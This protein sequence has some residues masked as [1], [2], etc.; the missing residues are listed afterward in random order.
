MRYKL[1]NKNK[2]LFSRKTY[3]Q[4][5]DKA[6]II[7]DKDGIDSIQLT[8]LKVVRPR[9]THVVPFQRLLNTY[10]AFISPKGK[11]YRLAADDYYF[12]KF[13]FPVFLL[14]FGLILFALGFGMAAAG[15]MLMVGFSP[16]AIRLFL[17]KKNERILDEIAAELKAKKVT[18]TNNA[19]DPYEFETYQKAQNFG[20]H[21]GATVI[22]VLIGFIVQLFAMGIIALLYGQLS[23][24]NTNDNKLLFTVLVSAGSVIITAIP[25]YFFMRFYTGVNF[26]W[27]DDAFKAMPKSHKKTS[28]ELFHRQIIDKR[29]AKNQ[30]LRSSM[31]SVVSILLIFAV[32]FGILF[33]KSDVFDTQDKKVGTISFEPSYASQISIEAKDTAFKFG[34]AV[35][36]K[37][38]MDVAQLLCRENDNVS[39]SSLISNLNAIRFEKN[40]YQNSI[41]QYTTYEYVL[42][43]FL[44]EDTGIYYTTLELVYVNGSNRDVAKY[45]I[46]TENE[47]HCVYALDINDTL[48]PT[49]ASTKKFLQDLIEVQY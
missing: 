20:R 8:G 38:A 26:K 28:E 48:Y 44:V 15:A 3:I 13:I 18:I 45:Q 29:L 16:G 10:L 36:Y 35:A 33:Y 6:L 12:E 7:H 40:D 5:S 37:D 47:K 49:D 24:H 1:Y 23:N 11:V 30:E 32:L 27:D 21:F 39:I 9:I 46:K 43:T 22:G 25:M 41:G 19:V 2:K 31:L 42:T 14:S 17:G 4:I 34:S